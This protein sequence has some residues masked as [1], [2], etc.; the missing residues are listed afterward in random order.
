[1][2]GLT[3]WGK[4][5]TSSCVD[6]IGRIGTGTIDRSI[7]LVNSFVESMLGTIIMFLDAYL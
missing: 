4:G 5:M 1:M 6:D 3:D 2:S 7:D